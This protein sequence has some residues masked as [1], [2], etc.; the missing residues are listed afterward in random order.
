MGHL[1]DNGFEVEVIES[2]NAELGVIR[3]QA[4]IRRNLAGCHTAFVEGYVIEGHVPADLV[5]RL[6]D[7]SPDLAGLVVPGMPIGSPGMEGPNP[8]PYDVLA[9]DRDGGTAVYDSR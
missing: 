9:L 8:Q 3:S 2:S 6:L 7:E 1:R 4:G 5:M